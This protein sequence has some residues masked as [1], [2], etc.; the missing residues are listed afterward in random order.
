M[1]SLCVLSFVAGFVLCAVVVAGAIRR[2]VL[3]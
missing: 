1:I 2:A 3:K